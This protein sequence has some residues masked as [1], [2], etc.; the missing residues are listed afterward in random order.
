MHVLITADTVGGVWT[1]TRELVTGV[2]RQGMRVTLVS[3]GGIPSPEQ[4]AWMDEIPALDYR[5]TGFRLEWMQGAE[6]EVEKSKTYL[7]T[8]VHEVKPNIL[9]LNQYAY[10]SVAPEIPR[11]VVAHSDVISWWVSVNGEEPPESA[12]LHW[13]RETV[14][15]AVSRAEA[16][17]APS[18]WMLDTICTHYGKPQRGLVIHNGRTPDQFA[19]HPAKR[20][21]VLAVGR[22]WDRGKQVSLLAN[23]CPG[24][25]VC[26][27]GSED[28]PEPQYRGDLGLGTATSNLKVLG[29]QS[30]EQLRALYAQASMYAA[31][32]C[33]EPFG[34]APLEAALSQCALVANDIPVFHELWG[35]SAYYFRK[36]DAQSLSSAIREISHNPA[37]RSTYARSAYERGRTRFSAER[38]CRDYESLYRRLA[39]CMENA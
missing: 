14:N 11:V 31:T 2:S 22:L 3:F 39:P 7:E 21:L 25:P 35:E 9:H 16:V 27:A 34:L 26:I 24:V 29:L 33:Y 5:P 15:T 10:G 12:W 32:S 18:Q 1:Y 38:M 36:N 20:P 37:L 23:A 6:G 13:Y 19:S 28:H 4:R 17:V 30:Q 8:V